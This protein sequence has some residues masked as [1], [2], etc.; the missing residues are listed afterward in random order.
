MVFKLPLKKKYPNKA[1][2]WWSSF[3]LLVSVEK[4]A[5]VM[6]LFHSIVIAFLVIFLFFKAISI[7]L[8][9]ILSEGR[10]WCL[11]WFYPQ[12]EWDRK[13][14]AYIGAPERTRRSWEEKGDQMTSKKSKTAWCMHGGCVYMTEK[15]SR[16]RLLE[17]YME[18]V[19]CLPLHR[20]WKEQ[21][22][23]R[24][25]MATTIRPNKYSIN[26]QSPFLLGYNAL[27]LT[28]SPEATFLKSTMKTGLARAACSISSQSA[29]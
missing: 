7:S 13:K 19:G 1:V 10:I 25:H 12:K 21:E 15:Y 23:S 22:P 26:H 14:E 9:S 29:L 27:S 4:L 8:F 20:F 24:Q 17:V 2:A 11:V 5:K 18:N 3:A 16:Q 28:V 6:T